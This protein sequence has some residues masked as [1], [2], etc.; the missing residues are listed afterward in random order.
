MGVLAGVAARWGI[1]S[2]GTGR[3]REAAES[4]KPSAEEKLEK[5]RSVQHAGHKFPDAEAADLAAA[6]HSKGT[7]EAVS[8]EFWD[9]P[10]FRQL[11]CEPTN[12]TPPHTNA[13][14]LALS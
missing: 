8:W 9:S 7:A 12:N 3:E 13:F 11:A 1:H 10:A 14:E 6:V 2:P 5:R 4:E